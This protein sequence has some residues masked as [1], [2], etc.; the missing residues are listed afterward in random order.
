MLLYA[1]LLAKDTTMSCWLARTSFSL[2]RQKTVKSLNI[3]PFFESVISTFSEELIICR[4][5]LLA[6]YILIIINLNNDYQVQELL[7][8]FEDLINQL[9]GKRVI[10]YVIQEILELISDLGLIDQVSSREF[11]QK[12]IAL[13]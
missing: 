10:V 9:N 5:I 1:P 8:V 4:M 13:S 6:F 2:K 7:I 3:E 12:A 11:D